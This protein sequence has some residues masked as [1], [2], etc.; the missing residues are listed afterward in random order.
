MIFQKGF[1]GFISINGMSVG[2]AVGFD[3]FLDKNRSLWIYNQ[4]AYLGLIIS[5]L[6]F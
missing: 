2:L 4:K 1:A 5:V 6:G 3:N